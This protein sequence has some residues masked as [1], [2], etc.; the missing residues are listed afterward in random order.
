[1]AQRTNSDAP[2]DEAPFVAQWTM[3]SAPTALPGVP[4]RAVPRRFS[5]GIVDPA[6]KLEVTL[7]VA[8]TDRPRIT[9]LQ[10]VT[11]DDQGVKPS[12]LSRLPL[13]R[14]LDLALDAVVQ[15]VEETG[16]GTYLVGFPDALSDADRTAATQLHKSKRRRRRKVTP[17]RLDHIAKL[18][19]EALEANE[20]TG[21][22]IADQEHVSAGTARQL[23]H[24]A[25]KAGRLG[26][27]TERQAGEE[28]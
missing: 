24:Q 16:P 3:V 5:A 6:R 10:V 26:S 1:M 23:V 11:G 17:E 20:P 28:R 2:A 12:E 14:Y 25:R 8:V 19:R 4:G 7:S 15:P 18:Y 22:Y 9:A 21:Q 27:T 13:G